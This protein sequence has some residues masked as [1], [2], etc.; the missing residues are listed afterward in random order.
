MGEP[1]SESGGEQFANRV[2][3][4]MS[5]GAGWKAKIIEALR[6]ESEAPGDEQAVRR[7]QTAL[8][9]LRKQHMWGDIDDDEYR[10]ER[11]PLERQL[12]LAA[13]T[14][15]TFKV[16]NLERAAELLND[17]STLWSNPGVTLEQQEALVREVFSRVTIDGKMFTSIEPKPVYAPL[18][19]SMAVNEG[20]GYRA[21]EP[22]PTPTFNNIRTRIVPCC[23]TGPTCPTPT[24]T[25]NN[26]RTRIVP[27]CVLESACPDGGDTP[28]R[29]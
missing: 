13:P 26:L 22:T 7:L 27:C 15:R 17:L 28:L 12:K 21:L 3:P 20:Y 25:F 9:N 2:L 23:V 1:P 11:I 5:L 14:P 19:A 8:K 4:G 6:E 18:F 10:Q 24:P 29:I 16:P